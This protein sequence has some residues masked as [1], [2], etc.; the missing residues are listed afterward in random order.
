[1]PQIFK[2]KRFVILF[3]AILFLIIG[4]FCFWNVNFNN[5]VS[6][7]G[8]SWLTGWSYR[9]PITVTSTSAATDYQVKLTVSY[10]ASKMNADFSD[11]RFTSSN[12][13]TEL[14][15]WIESYTAST[16]AIVWV[17]VPS[18]ASGANTIYMYYGKSSVATTSN[19]TNTFIFFD[20]F[21]GTLSKWMSVG[22]NSQCS[23]STNSIGGGVFTTSNNYGSAN[24]V[25]L[26]SASPLS[27]TDNFIVG[28]KF[29]M[30]PACTY[31]DVRFFLN[32]KASTQA[33][34]NGS[35]IFYREGSTMYNRLY[36]DYNTSSYTSVSSLADNTYYKTEISY[37][38][39]NGKINLYTSDGT[40]LGT[41]SGTIPNGGNYISVGNGGHN[42]GS[43]DWL[44]VRKYV[45]SEPTISFGAEG[46]P[47]Y[48]FSYRTPIMINNTPNSSTLT[49]YQILVTVDTASL[50][51]A[52]KLQSDCDDISFTDNSTSYNSGDWTNKYPYWIESGCNTPTTKI[53]V[54][55]DSIAALS[56]KSIYMYYG[57]LSATIASSGTNT[58]VFFD[59]FTGTTIN[60][61]KWIKTDSGGYISQNGVLTISNGTATWGQTEMH[62][63]S[64]FN[65]ADGLV[66]QGKYKST[67]VR[68]ASYTDTTMLW[69]KDSGTGTNY[70]DYIYALYPYESSGAAFAMYEDGNSRGTATGTFTANTQ[71][72]IRQII[73]SAGALT[74]ISTDG[75]DTWT[76]SYNSTY[77]TETPFKVGFTHYQGGDVIIDNVIVRKYTSTEPTVTVINESL[78]GCSAT[79]GV[80]TKI[81][82]YCIHTFISS[83]TFYP[84]SIASVEYLVVGG[85]G[86]GGRE[87]STAGSGGGAGGLLTSTGLAITPGSSITVTVG[88]GGVD[89][90]GVAGTNGGN[91]VFS[92][93]TA[94]GG[95]GG[96]YYSGAD[97]GSGGGS[98][99]GGTAGG[100]GTQ[101]NNPAGIGFGHDGGLGAS[102]GGG[103]G[104]GGGAA[105]GNASSGVG[106]SGGAGISSS[107][108]GTATYYAGGGGG[109]G[110]STAGS[111]GS[112]IGGAGN[113][114]N[115]NGGNGVANTGSGGGGARIGY[116]VGS[117]GSGIVIVKYL[118]DSTSPVIAQVTAVPSPTSDT[119]PDYTFSSTEAGTI[120]YGGDCSSSTTSAVSGNNTITFNILAEGTHSN[121]TIKVADAS[122]N[123]SNT[124]TVNS[125]T[126]ASHVSTVYSNGVFSCFVSGDCGT[127]TTILKLSDYMGGHA[128]LSSGSVYEYK[129]CC[130]G[131][132]ISNSCSGGS[133]VLR[134]SASTDAH[135]EQN[136]RS[137]SAYNS[138]SVCISGTTGM[139][140]SYASSCSSLGS[141]YVCLASIS[142]DTNAHVAECGVYSTQVC[143]QTSVPTNSCIAKISAVPSVD[144]AGS[145][146]LCSDADIT[147]SSDPCYSTCWTG[148]GTPV[149]TDSDWKCSTCKDTSN[150]TI[151]CFNS[152]ATYS[153]TLS[154][155]HSSSSD[156]T[157]TSGGLSSANLNIN[158]I[159]A[160]K[161]RKAT[162]SINSNLCNAT[163]GALSPV[164]KEVSP[165]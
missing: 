148:T 112:G 32:V 132:G 13:S 5:D 126:I 28:T 109:S 89:G 33:A 130:S 118:I 67:M 142:G 45:S 154:G 47:P 116:I 3:S 55:V 150:N 30:M 18:L 42:Y 76:D 58:F 163:T 162:L 88:A 113:I 20:D 68:G 158:F 60:T 123:N 110:S 77:S 93:I 108:T 121:C 122:N 78:D 29:K 69:I 62:T 92:T 31:A 73:K 25:G 63:V 127:G 10:I 16:S 1:M 83:G 24:T 119:T 80:I 104:G 125:F 6:A 74:Q 53:W 23:P 56:Y 146:Q 111:G 81:S 147:N 124:L 151:P 107:I 27:V 7:A 79:G 26:T 43:V 54:K 71:Y 21:N 15:Y 164:W 90:G 41:N 160:D 9:K 157:I 4:G 8:E 44:Y 19:G 136:N 149:V 128:E 64:D 66:V 115:G 137:N 145:V 117:G 36:V 103:G 87:A 141:N 138:N 61:S 129:V 140:C 14:S 85:G 94:T 114:G 159:V 105:G 82:G 49:N 22:S 91:S 143:C 106:G 34:I 152:G 96:S 134:L 120:T 95:G 153:W 17:K 11:L 50:V 35:C 131:T 39:G 144:K 37:Y 84:N 97:G 99:P 65:R 101:N 72:N 155:G 102:N 165:F 12:G 70:T 57:N 133:T 161:T 46:E 2:D 48:T 38:G 40:L 86:A 98:G 51:S 52:G 100:T 139:T 75:G 59:D 135:V 156:Y